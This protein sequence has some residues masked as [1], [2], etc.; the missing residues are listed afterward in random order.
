MLTAPCL[1]LNEKPAAKRSVREK[2]IQ[3]LSRKTISSVPDT[4]LTS[5]V[6]TSSCIYESMPR[7]T[8]AKERFGRS[9][10]VGRVSVCC[11]NRELDGTEAVKWYKH[12]YG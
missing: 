11:F 4:L 3:R 2:L 10:F 12:Y 8:F 9:N 7:T 6:V 5:P 1:F